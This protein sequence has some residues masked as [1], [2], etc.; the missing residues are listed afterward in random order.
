M[1][2]V[3]EEVEGELRS[4][5]YKELAARLLPWLIGGLLV[6]VVLIGGALGWQK[7]QENQI[8]KA[9]EAYAQGL[10]TL[11]GGDAEAAFRQFGKVPAGAKG[12]RAL[13][14]MQQGGIRLNAGKAKEAQQLLDQAAD[15]AP[16]NKVGRIIGDAA[17]LKSAFAMMDQASYADIEARL[18]PLTEDDRP[19]RAQARE[20]LALAKIQAGKLKEAKQD[21]TVLSLMSEAPEGLQ[22][23]ARTTVQMIDSGLAA[24][25][26]AVVKAAA[27]LPP[28]PQMTPEMMQALQAMQGQ[29][30]PPPQGAAPPAAGAAQ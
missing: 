12:Y 18:K 26:P 6:A 25:V 19:Y 10:E 4:E 8:F 16:N 24:D 14:L 20:A 17:R 22:A 1:V 2:D 7:Y 9:S 13:A 30:G 11:Q 23:R 5:R 28:Q 21:L 27:A 3:F 15:A 29:G